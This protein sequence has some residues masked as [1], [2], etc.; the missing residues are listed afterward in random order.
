[1]TRT[2][3]IGY[4]TLFA[5][6]TVLIAILVCVVTPVLN[7]ESSTVYGSNKIAANYA[8]PGLT[9]D[10]YA[11]ESKVTIVTLIES[12][13]PAMLPHASGQGVCGVDLTC[14]SNGN[15]LP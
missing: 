15:A 13:V 9:E 8:M 1:M 11:P 3:Q 7:A 2:Q 14:D 6:L 5:S 12:I 4:G 10:R